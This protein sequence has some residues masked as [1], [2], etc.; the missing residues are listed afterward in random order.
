MTLKSVIALLTL[1]FYVS[2]SAQTW[3][4]EDIKSTTILIERFN[5]QDPEETF[6]E[7]DER[8][9][10]D[11][12]AFISAENGHMDKDN[13]KLDALFKQCTLQYFTVSPSKVRSEYPD[14]E[15]FRYILRREVFLGK[16]KVFNASTKKI[17]D[18]TYFG[19]KYYFYDRKSREYYPSYYFSGDK[20]TQLERVIFWLNNYE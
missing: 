17:E 9:E 11:K 20:W 14:K 10:D 15:E 12:I 8:Y 3:I 5:Y 1:C 19:Y 4:P 7:V 6:D 18:Q 16:K 13:L 2:V